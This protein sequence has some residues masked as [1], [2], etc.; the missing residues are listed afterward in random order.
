MMTLPD[1]T[2]RARQGRALLRT[3]SRPTGRHGAKPEEVDD[4]GAPD[5]P[6]HNP[7]NGRPDPRSGQRL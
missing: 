7:G 5:E 3:D 4:D 6:A 2:K 1:S